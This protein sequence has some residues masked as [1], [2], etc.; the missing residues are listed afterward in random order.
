MAEISDALTG[1]GDPPLAPS[2]TVASSV[3]ALDPAVFRSYLGNLLPA[4][5]GASQNDVD[6]LFEGASGA[7]VDEKADKFL[8][9]STAGVVY[10]NQVKEPLAYG[11]CTCC[12]LLRNTLLHPRP[13][14]SCAGDLGVADDG[15]LRSDPPAYGGRASNSTPRLVKA[16]TQSM[17]PAFYGLE[18]GIVRSL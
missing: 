16:A 7:M 2:T 11:E 17:T 1:G 4:V 15:S 13:R 10:V 18:E 14:S 6:R 9:D 3:A 8:R 12:P 5:L